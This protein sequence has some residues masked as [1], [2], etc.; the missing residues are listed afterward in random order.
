MDDERDPYTPKIG[1]KFELE[2]RLIR[3][4]ARAVISILVIIAGLIALLMA[5]VY[6]AWRGDYDALN[7]TVLIVSPFI[8]VIL[9]WYF[10]RD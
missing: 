5:W 6:S 1:E 4:E 7:I 2:M 3:E 10:K 9:N 8:F